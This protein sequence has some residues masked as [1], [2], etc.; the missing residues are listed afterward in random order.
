MVL[1]SIR[2]KGV[3]RI[4]P[5]KVISPFYGEIVIYPQRQLIKKNVA[6]WAKAQDIS[7]TSGPL[8]GLP[9]GLIW[10]VSA[11]AP[12]NVRSRVPQF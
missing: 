9:S 2:G 8:W 12:A 1:N 3:P 4:S 5:K 6:I 7:G 11:Y 10:Q